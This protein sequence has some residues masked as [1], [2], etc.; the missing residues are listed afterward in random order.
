MRILSLALTLIFEFNIVAVLLLVLA[1]A[2]FP[3]ANN[4]I[5]PPIF[6]IKFLRLLLMILCF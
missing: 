1:L 6:L 2:A 3:T 5:E 4:A